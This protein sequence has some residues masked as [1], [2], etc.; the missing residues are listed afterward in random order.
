MHQADGLPFRER[1]T[2]KG[3]NP[4]LSQG[5]TEE[6]VLRNRESV[7]RWQRKFMVIAVPETRQSLIVSVRY[8][9]TGGNSLHMNDGC[10]ET[11]W[12]RP[13]SQTKIPRSSPR[14][15]VVHK[16]REEF[17]TF[18]ELPQATWRAEDWGD[19]H[20][21][22]EVYHQEMDDR[23]FL[24]GLPDDQ[25]H[26]P[27]WG[28]VIKGRLRVLYGGREEEI[29]AKHAYYLAPG[30]SIIVDAGTELI[31]FS[32]REQFAAHMQAV[33]EISRARPES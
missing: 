23:P 19:M 11:N 13:A 28:F 5:G 9:E 26:C 15:R 8:G 16:S 17:A 30:H 14:R 7:S 24:Q 32:P 20:V 10:G 1:C 18:F 22:F 27:H 3:E 4:V 12:L 31:E 6:A 29:P 21:S 2:L 25:C 33:E